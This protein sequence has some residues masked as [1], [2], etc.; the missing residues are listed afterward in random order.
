MS[1]SNAYQ[2]VIAG[3]VREDEQIS[4]F[5]QNKIATPTRV[6]NFTP[7]GGKTQPTTQKDFL[8]TENAG[9]QV[10]TTPVLDNYIANANNIS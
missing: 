10:N 8:H 1:A 4:F 6:T 3:R 5:G 9:K 7:T 2:Q